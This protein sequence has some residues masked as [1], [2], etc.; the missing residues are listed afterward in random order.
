M[1]LLNI[2]PE[3]NKIHSNSTFSYV[4]DLNAFSVFA[5][6]GKS[7]ELFSG[8]NMTLNGINDSASWLEEAYGPI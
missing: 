7:S 6:K 5:S 1:S 8:Q 2:Y 3:K 4:T